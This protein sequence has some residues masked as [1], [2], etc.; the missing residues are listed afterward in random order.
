MSN[1]L[2]E[3]RERERVHVMRDVSAIAIDLFEERGYDNVT[4]DEV[5]E[6][7]GVS[8]ATLYRRFTTKEN[9]VCW[10]P[11][12]QTGMATY[13]AAIQSG[14]AISSAAKELAYA[15]S[16]E[17]VEAVEATARKRLRLIAGHPSLQA[18]ARKKGESFVTEVLAASSRDDGHTL[19]ERET[20]ARCVAAALDAASNAWLRGEGSLR[21]CAIRALDLLD[22]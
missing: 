18:A 12:E 5:A 22:R 15:F 4:M 11:D 17:A 9:L 8:V 13:L 1:R 14:Q 3:A 6:A 20:Q 16:D 10:Q 7:T 21:E 2:K 19:L